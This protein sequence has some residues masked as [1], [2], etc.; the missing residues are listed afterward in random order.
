MVGRLSGRSGDRTDAW[1]SDKFII[2]II[3]TNVIIDWFSDWL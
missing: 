3:A 2:E 1:M